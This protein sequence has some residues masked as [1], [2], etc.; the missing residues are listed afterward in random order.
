VGERQV[1]ERQQEPQRAVVEKL[2]AGALAESEV[3]DDIIKRFL[4]GLLLNNEWAEDFENVHIAIKF[5]HSD[6]V[7]TPHIT[8]YLHINKRFLKDSSDDN[9]RFA[10]SVN[11]RKWLDKHKGEKHEQ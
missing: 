9:Y 5:S 11:G 8:D 7:C 1:S 3:D 6:T 10:I 2:V 4:V